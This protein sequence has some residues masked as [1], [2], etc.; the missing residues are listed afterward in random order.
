MRTFGVRHVYGKSL[1]KLVKEYNEHS[2]KYSCK[3]FFYK[4]FTKS[5]KS[6]I[7]CVYMTVY[8][9]KKGK[10][11]ITFSNNLP[12]PSGTLYSSID[13]LIGA[14]TGYNTEIVSCEKCYIIG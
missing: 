8:Q 2:D 7:K 5:E 3:D 13:S 6:V 4:F 14:K 12:Q 10:Q 11:Y 1:D 9:N